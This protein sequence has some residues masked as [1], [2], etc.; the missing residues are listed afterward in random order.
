MTVI[1]EGVETAEQC[2]WVRSAGCDMV[3]G[4]YYAKSMSIKDYEDLVYGGN[5]DEKARD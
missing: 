5:I 3:Q 1:V 4:W 2:D